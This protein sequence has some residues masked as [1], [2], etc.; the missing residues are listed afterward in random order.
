MGWG[1]ALAV[2]VLLALLPLGVDADYGSGGL[3]V[4][5]VAGPIRFTVY[6]LKK[7]KPKAE[8]KK[9][10]QPKGQKR[11]A[12]ASESKP[13]AGGS[14]ADFLPLVQLCFDF[15]GDLRRKLRVNRLEMTLIMAADDPCDLAVSYG[16][17][18][19]AVG[20]LMPRLERLFVIQ[21]KDIRVACDFE[22]EQTVLTARLKLTVT[23]GRILSLAA[24]YGI[25]AVK[26]FVKLTNQRK[27]GMKL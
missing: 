3:T 24:V 5:V 13:K 18:W 11:S 14:L 21:K 9:E 15:L 1:I 20:N 17:A 10:E 26:E 6:P 7:R 4:K 8:E 12:A 16:R 19:A 22:A 27:G 23:L 2:I 25:R